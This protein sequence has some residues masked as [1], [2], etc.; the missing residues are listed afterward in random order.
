M[1]MT[2]SEIIIPIVTLIS[3]FGNHYFLV[4]YFRPFR[5]LAAMTEGHL[6]PAP[7]NSLVEV[8]D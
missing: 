4:N 8:Y 1:M 6:Q 3:F 7:S 2:R 5:R